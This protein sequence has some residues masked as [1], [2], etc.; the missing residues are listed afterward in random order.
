MVV[1]GENPSVE[2][3]GDIVTDIHLSHLF[4]E[5]HFVVRDLD[6]FLEGNGE[7]VFTGV[8]SLGDTRVG[9]I[10]TDNHI[11]L[12]FARCSRGFSLLEFLV[13]KGVL[14]FGSLVVGRNID[15]GDK[16]VD[17][18]SS[19]FNGTVPKVLVHDFATTHTDVLVGLKR[20]SN[21]DLSSSR[22][23]KIHSSDLTI[24]NGFWNVEFTNHAHR[25]SSSAWLGIVHLTFEDD[26]IDSLF[27][28]KDFGGACSRRTSSNNG[29]LVSHVHVRPVGGDSIERGRTLSEEGRGGCES[30]GGSGKRSKGD[31]GKFHDCMFF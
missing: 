11:D 2:I 22:G 14:S 3:R 30:T 13:V 10:S 18:L 8:H 15:F 28:G 12:H 23:D 5:N 4:V 31:D 16:P 20:I 9:T 1:L 24:D 21:G 26:R 27:L 25:D 7:V 17:W 6:S 19:E 29:D